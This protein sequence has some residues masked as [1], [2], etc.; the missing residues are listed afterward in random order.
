MEHQQ[1]QPG[2]TIYWYDNRRRLIQQNP[3]TAQ[4]EILKDLEESAVGGSLIM[5][6]IFVAFDLLGL[7]GLQIPHSAF[8]DKFLRARSLNPNQ[9]GQAVRAIM[10]TNSQETYKEALEVA[11]QNYP[12]LNL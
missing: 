8:I 12:Q 2:E 5:D 11:R 10:A 4:R 1:L 7:I 9:I 6:T 3:E